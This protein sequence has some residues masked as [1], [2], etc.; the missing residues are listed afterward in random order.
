MHSDCIIMKREV[1]IDQGVIGVSV[2]LGNESHLFWIAIGYW[3]NFSN[4]EV[5]LKVHL[6]DWFL[7]L[8]ILYRYTYHHLWQAQVDL[9]PTH[10]PIYCA[11]SLYSQAIWWCT[12]WF[13]NN[14]YQIFTL[15]LHLLTNFLWEPGFWAKSWRLLGLGAWT[16]ETSQ[17]GKITS[18][19]IK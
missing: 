15:N 4:I 8:F 14:I 18:V 10:A 17:R 5:N 19:H 9:E 6:S 7:V 12:L 1:D 3:L 2:N 13:G 16:L 11:V